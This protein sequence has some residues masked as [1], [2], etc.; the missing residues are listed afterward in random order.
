LFGRSDKQ[1]QAEHYIDH[2]DKFP[3]GLLSLLHNKESFE[4]LLTFRRLAVTVRTVSED[5][6]P[7]MREVTGSDSGES[8]IQM[9]EMKPSNM[10]P[11][12]PDLYVL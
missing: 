12:E 8:D 2:Y 3:L 1:P 4:R 5:K 6:E 10:I 9:P 7:V 11:I